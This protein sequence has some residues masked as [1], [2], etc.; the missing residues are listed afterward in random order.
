LRGIA[1]ASTCTVGIRAD[2]VA[3]ARPHFRKG[4]CEDLADDVHFALERDSAPGIDGVTWQAYGEDLEEKLT[5]LLTQETA[6]ISPF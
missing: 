3:N 2:D 1:H 4:I 5:K 6:N